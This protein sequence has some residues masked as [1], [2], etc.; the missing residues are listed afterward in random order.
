MMEEQ[1]KQ[2]KEYMDNSSYTV[3]VTGAGISYMY[4]MRRFKEDAARTNMPRMMSS[5]YVKKHPDEVYA[6]FKDAFLDAT[7]EKGPSPV[8]YQMAELEK[9]GLLQ[10][11]VTQNLDHLHQLAGSENVVAFMGDFSNTVCIDCG[12]RYDDIN[13]WNQG[14]MPRCPK[15]GGYLLPVFFER[16]GRLLPGGRSET[17]EWIKQAQDMIAQA[18]LVIFIGTTGFQSDQYLAKL[19]SSTKLVQINPGNT[20]FDQIVN[21]NIRKDAEKVFNQILA[22]E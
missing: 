10:G 17:S 8:H 3:A 16:S 18:E 13:V 14:E 4:G 7:F 12:A 20:M 2:L 19:R 1:V 22:E 9:R 6:V 21:L 15:C 5:G 11:I